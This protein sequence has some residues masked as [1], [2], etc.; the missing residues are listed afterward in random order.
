[1]AAGRKR[2]N[3]EGSIYKRTDGRYVGSAFVPVLGGGR[4]RRYVYG[5]TRQ[6]ARDA[7]DDLLRKAAAGV[8]RPLKRATVAEYLDYWLD[9]VVKPELR[10]TTYAGYETMVRVHIKPV[11]GRKKLDELGPADVRHLL[12]VLREKETTGHGGGRRTLS[13]R[14]VQFAHAVLRNALSNAVREELISRNAAKLVKMS[15][16]E[17]D[18]GTGLDPIAARALLASITEDRLYAL[19]VCAIVLGMRRGELLGLMW[20]AVDLDGNRLVVRQSLSWVNGRAVLQPPKTRTSRRVIPLPDVVAT[21]LR[22]HRK[23]QD[24]ERVDA[25]DGWEDSGFVFT[26]RR[27]APMSPYTLSKYW[28]DLREKA[29]LG[30]LRFHDLRH[31]A[32]SLL[33]AL[34]VPPHVVREIAGHSDIKVT[35]TVYAHGNLAEK[36]AA[37]SQLGQALS[38]G[39]LS[40]VA[41]SPPER[42]DQDQ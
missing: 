32:V 24:A 42:K 17:Y 10:P 16:P 9:E 15:N 4:Q 31:T 12:A 11:L 34:G 35:M 2:A 27:G 28:R 19:Y 8:R 29:G 40:P 7:L 6:D 5:R 25:G 37:L 14:M 1:M 22:E 41:V 30:T 13:K 33:L 39:L 21:A 23:R 38:G 18:V 36:A 3:G 20:A 26:T